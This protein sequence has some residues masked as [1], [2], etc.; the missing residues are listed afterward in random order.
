MIRTNPKPDLLA[1]F[2]DVSDASERRGDSDAD[3]QRERESTAR[4]FQS[5]RSGG[6]I[7][8]GRSKKLF[9]LLALSFSRLGAAG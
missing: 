3:Q 2:S 1:Y 8:T 7:R 4:G 9:S 6:V 5:P